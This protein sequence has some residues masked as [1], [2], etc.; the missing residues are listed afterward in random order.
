MHREISAHLEKERLNV[1]QFWMVFSVIINDLL[2]KGG[3]P[4]HF[5]PAEDVVCFNNMLD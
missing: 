3:E 5:S 1:L 4:D 2:K